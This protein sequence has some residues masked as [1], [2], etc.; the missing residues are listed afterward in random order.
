MRSIAIAALFGAL[1]KY[2][3]IPAWWSLLGIS[4]VIIPLVLKAVII[5]HADTIVQY[6]GVIVK[7]PKIVYIATGLLA[8]ITILQWINILSTI[9]YYTFRS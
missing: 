1:Y 4:M 2:Q 7:A 9:L 5:Y 6:K 3:V 8:V